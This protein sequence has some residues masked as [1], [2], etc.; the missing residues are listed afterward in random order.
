[1]DQKRD[2][3]ASVLATIYK[4]QLLTLRQPKLSREPETATSVA[5]CLQAGFVVPK[6]AVLGVFKG[7]HGPHAFHGSHTLYPGWLVFKILIF[8]TVLKFSAFFFFG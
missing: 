6:N 7:F 3:R 8:W 2:L 1:M 4:F 5:L